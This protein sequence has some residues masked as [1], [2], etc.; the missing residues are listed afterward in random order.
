MTKHRHTVTNTATGLVHDTIDAVD[1]ATAARS[2]ATLVGRD[3]LAD[4]I[5]YAAPDGH[6]ARLSGR[7]VSRDRRVSFM[8]ERRY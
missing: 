7:H 8:I 1:A 2:W 3:V 4:A 5:V 6:R